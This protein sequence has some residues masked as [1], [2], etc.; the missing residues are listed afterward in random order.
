M[1]LRQFKTMNEVHETSGFIAALEAFDG[2]TQLQELKALARQR[3]GIADGQAVLDVGCGFGLETLRLAELTGPS[4]RLTGIDLSP[5]FIQEAQK[6][7]R[8]A[9]QDIRYQVGDAC[10]LPFE[11]NS[12]DC[13]RAERMLIY[14]KDF[15][16]ALREMQRVLKPGGRLALIEPDFSTNTINTADRPLMRRIMDYEVSRAVEQAWLPGP[17][18]EALQDLGFT[19]IAIASRVLIF[20]QDLG[21]GYFSGLGEKALQAGLVSEAELKD[22]QNEIA[23]LRKKD[24]LFATIGYFL[25]TATCP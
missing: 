4:G 23:K 11:A 2:I 22:W 1:D 13:V 21:A 16:T 20:P 6:R 14:L 10:D 8:S 17:L 9:G 12:F 24:H 3:T 15:T 18:H 5:D 25:F 19:E 7:A